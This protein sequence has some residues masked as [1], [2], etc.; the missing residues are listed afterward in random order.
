[1][2][3]TTNYGWTTPNDTDLVKDGAAAIRTLG[4]SIDT[5][6][7]ANASAGIAKSIVDAK[8]DLIAGTAA[9]TVARLA[10]GT[11]DQILVAD[12]TAATGMKWATPTG[13]GGMTLLSTTTLSGAEVTISS[14]SQDYNSLVAYVYGVTNATADGVLY[15]KP[16]TDLGAI[17]TSQA[18]NS[19]WT[20]KNGEVPKF[21]SSTANYLMNRTSSN[22]SFTLVIDNYTNADTGKPFQIYGGYR[23]AASFSDD[24]WAN[25]VGYIARASGAA[26]TSLVFGNTGGNLSTGTVKLYGVK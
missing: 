22:N 12:S 26:I 6:V 14:I 20:F 18:T 16:N 17:F 15:V 24:M 5:T 23:A 7:F 11:N 13:G 9:D 8:G 3:T 21:T 4:S 19:S 25:Q 10:V 1:M 2:A